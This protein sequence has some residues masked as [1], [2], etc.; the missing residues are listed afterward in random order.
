MSYAINVK[1]VKIRK[2]HKCWGCGRLFPTGTLMESNVSTDEGKIFTTY[3]CETCQNVVDKAADWYEDE[4]IGFMEL[5]NNY[6]EEYK[7][8]EP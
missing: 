4:G 2:P 3:F 7:I 5:I 8:I 6:P 1:E